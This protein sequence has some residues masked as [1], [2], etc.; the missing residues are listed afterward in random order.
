M[1]AAAQAAQDRFGQVD[2]LVNNAGCG[3]PA[4]IEEGEDTEVRA[5]F[6]ANFFGLLA[7]IRALLPGMRPRELPCHGLLSRDETCGGG[8]VGGACAGGGAAGDQ[9]P[10]RGTWP[11]PDQLGGSVHQAVR[12]PDRG[13]C[14]HGRCSAIAHRG[15]QRQAA[16]DP[17]RAVE[18]I[19]A[20]VRSDHPPLRLVLGK[21]ALDIARGKIAALKAAQAR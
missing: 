4:A 7:I 19:I 1:A 8:A 17:V 9:G 3:Y 11:V 5:M 2:V 12:G 13:L 10:G 18:A 6:E 14:C 15:A 16:G 20:A 21:P